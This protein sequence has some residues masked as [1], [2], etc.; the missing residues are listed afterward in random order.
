MAA[1]KRNIVQIF[2][3]GLTRRLYLSNVKVISLH[4][5]PPTMMIYI[6]PPEKPR[7]S[8][9]CLHTSVESFDASPKIG[10]TTR[11]SQQTH[12]DT[13]RGENPA[14]PSQVKNIEGTQNELSL[15]VCLANMYIKNTPTRFPNV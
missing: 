12:T 2:W 4:E 14:N 15:S 6:T 10:N 13:P 5:G 1:V 9:S 11:K 3:V 7:V 8:C